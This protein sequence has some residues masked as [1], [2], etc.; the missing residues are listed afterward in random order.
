MTSAT[1]GSEPLSFGHCRHRPADFHESG[2]RRAVRPLLTGQIY[3]LWEYVLRK[4]V[5]LERLGAYH[6]SLLSF[7]H[8]FAPGV[9]PGFFWN[10][11]LLTN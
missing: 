3:D 6:K 11:T 10:E 9:L 1:A 8:T 4:R 5:A 2:V 7:G